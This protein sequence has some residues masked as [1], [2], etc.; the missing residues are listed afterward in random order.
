MPK[1]SPIS[2]AEVRLKVLWPEVYSGKGGVVISG[3]QAASARCRVAVVVGLRMAVTGRQ[4]LVGVLVVPGDDGGVGQGDVEQ[5]E[6]A[7]VLG[8]AVA[9]WRAIAAIWFQ[10]PGGVSVPTPSAQKRAIWV[11]SAVRVVLLVP[12]SPWSG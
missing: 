2:W 6:E 8:E 3:V 11:W 4:M 9:P 10:C 1:K 7:G 5:G 12:R